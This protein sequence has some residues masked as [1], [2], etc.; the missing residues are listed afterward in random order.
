[1]CSCS[2]MRAARVCSSSSSNTGTVFCTTM[3][4]GRVLHPQNAPCIPRLS[5]RRRRPAPALPGRGTPAGA[6]DGYS[7]CGC[8]NCC[9]NHGESR[10]MY[11]AR[12]I[13]STLC[14]CNA[15]T[16]SRSCSSRGFALGRDHQRLQS[17]LAGGFD[18][19]SVGL[20]RDDDSDVGVGN[21]A[22]VD[23]V[24]D[25]DKVGAAS[26]KQDGE[27]AFAIS[28]WRF[29]IADFGFSRETIHLSM[30]SSPGAKSKI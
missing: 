29:Q 5:P 10:R 27:G 8:G 12:Q 3:A 11:P 7:E 23:V 4:R 25:G 9:T 30:G 26:G 24:G 22:G 14:S 18:A 19:G 17:A 1:M 28:D 21:V 13:R 6:M 2:R 15:A 16:T 20:I